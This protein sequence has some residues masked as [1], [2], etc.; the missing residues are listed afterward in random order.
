[1]TRCGVNIIGAGLAGCEA[2]YQLARRS[3]KVCLFDIKPKSFTSAH[4][5]PYFA[6]LVCSNSLKSDEL[7]NACGLLKQEM[8]EIGSLI[9]SCADMHRVPAGSALAVDREK[10]TR[11][12][13]ERIKGFDNIHIVCREVTS[14]ESGAYTIIASGPLTTPALAKEIMRLSGAENLYFFDAA[15]PIVDGST[16]D[17]ERAFM[18]DRYGKGGGDYLNCPMDEEEYYAFVK[19]LASAQ[20]VKLKD[21]EDDKVFEGCVPIEVMARRSP[22]SLRF[23]PL[24]PVGL[25]G[26]DGKMPFAVVQLRRENL[27]G[28]YYNMVGFQT[29][30]LFSEQKKV[31][32]M[33]PA[34]K[35]AEFVKYG[36]MHKNTYINSPK[37]LNRFY[38]LRGAD[39]IFFAGQLCGVEGYVESA[40]S[41]QVAGI[42]L[43][44]MLCG[45]P[46]VDFTDM[47]VTGALSCYVSAENPNFQPMNANFAILKP[48]EGR[49]KD[50]KQKYM[51]Y[52]ERSLS[53]IR[54][55][56]ADL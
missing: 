6:E 17:M 51:A 56:A 42:N 41:G 14:I 48:L 5:S 35:S 44:R 47:T 23:G 1:M 8:R 25:A 15:A 16:I 31:F 7:T 2:A 3:V 9:M 54:K 26:K 11:E 21:F 18:A 29:N 55:I 19:E 36:V 22:D 40:S 20:T 43:Y 12:V 10:F 33:V 24:R 27:E 4:S 46:P 37:V 52:A 32:S 34:L 30:L 13:T 45:R 49:F 38:Q 39:N 53:I 50:K 28:S